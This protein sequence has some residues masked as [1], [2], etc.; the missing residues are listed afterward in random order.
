[1]M[2]PYFLV[3][4]FIGTLGTTYPWLNLLILLGVK[5]LGVAIL[6]IAILGVA[7]L[8]AATLGVTI[9]LT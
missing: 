1:M 2:L 5:A 3:Y 6:G 7:I 8:G 9:C 4:N